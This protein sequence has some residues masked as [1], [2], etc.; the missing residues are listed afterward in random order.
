MPPPSLESNWTFHEPRREVIKTDL[1]GGMS[2]VE[3][4]TRWI[5]DDGGGW[6]GM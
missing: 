4:F 1:R 3:D 5:Q 2:E 6:G